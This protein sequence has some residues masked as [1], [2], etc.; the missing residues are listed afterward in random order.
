MSQ[1]E[2]SMARAAIVALQRPL[3]P[4]LC[5]SAITLAE[6]F[7]AEDRDTPRA[8]SWIHWEREIAHGADGRE[9]M[10]KRLVRI[11]VEDAAIQTAAPAII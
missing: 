7:F 9:R 4:P 5:Q 8:R 10:R 1:S 11:P 2:P 3:T 6:S